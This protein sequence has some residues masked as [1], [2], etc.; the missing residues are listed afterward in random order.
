MTKMKTET[1]IRAKIIKLFEKYYYK[2]L[3]SI[4]FIFM[5]VLLGGI[6]LMNDITFISVF[7]MF[8]IVFF[9]GVFTPPVFAIV[10]KK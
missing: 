7:Y 9:V 1:K 8:L 3:T 4:L 10:M 5:L 2:T 6:Y